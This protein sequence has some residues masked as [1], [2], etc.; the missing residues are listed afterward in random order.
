M[1][2]WALAVVAAVLVAVAAAVLKRPSGRLAARVR[3]PI[4]RPRMRRLAIERIA[5][6]LTRLRCDQD[7]NPD[8]EF[9]SEC[10]RWFTGDPDA[11][12]DY[13]A[14]QRRLLERLA[15]GSFGYRANG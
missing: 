5:A 7:G 10:Y 1:N 9:R 12:M 8:D 13:E 15:R 3:G 14:K 2:P 4:R 6:E 11:I